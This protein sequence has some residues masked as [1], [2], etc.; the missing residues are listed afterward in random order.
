MSLTPSSSVYKATKTLLIIVSFSLLAF[1]IWLAYRYWGTWLQLSIGWQKQLNQG[2]S[3][4]LQETSSHPLYAGSLLIAVSFLYGFLHALGPGH[5]KLI[6]TT[7]IATQR[8]HLK[9]SV[10]ISLLASLLQGV[11]AIT[12]VSVVLV[13]FQ[14]ST[15]H[16]NQV[17]LYAEQLSYL[18]VIILGCFLCI[19]ALRR[20]WQ[21]RLSRA[22][23]PLVIKNL[24]PLTQSTK[25]MIQPN[26]L[27]PH[28]VCH[29][30]HQHVIQSHQI[31]SSFKSKVLIILSMGARP[32][33]GAILVLLFSYVIEVYA[34]G[35][36]A[37]LA[38]AVGT[39]LTICLIAIFVHFMRDKAI[40]LSRL[41]GK[42]LSPYWGI[43]LKIFAGVFFILMGALMLQSVGLE[44][45]ISPLLR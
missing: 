42:Q 44:Q 19:T 34:W 28:P 40:R 11:V 25:R 6:I 29:C 31:Q 3:N 9:Q 20:Y 39:A 41:T 27:T 21:T 1:A 37:A 2:L 45:S 16:L 15:K 26:T 7:Y 17:S 5:G 36:I 38:M 18:F 30:G 35:V 43:A 4:L 24:K 22:L 10:I 23:S 14:L 8:T 33:S 32:C 12:L 13:L